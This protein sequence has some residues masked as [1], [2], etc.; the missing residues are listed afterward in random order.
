M[1]T[2]RDLYDIIKPHAPKC[3]FVELMEERKLNVQARLSTP[4]SLM[5]QA[6]KFIAD[7]TQSVEENVKIFTEK[8]F[9]TK[10]DQSIIFQ[11]TIGQSSVP[12]WTEQRKGRLT[13]SRFHQI[14]TRTKTLQETSSKDASCLL[15]SLLCY[16][17]MPD[18]ASIKHGCAMEPHAKAYYLP[19]TKKKHRKLTSSEAGLVVKEEKPYI[20][21]SSDLQIECICCGKGLVEVNCP[22]SIR[23]TVPSAENLKYLEMIGGKVVLKKNSN[24]YYQIQGQM[25]VTGRSYTDLVIFTS[26]KNII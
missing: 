5:V 24:Y 15:S 6:Q 21:V 13:A 3:C 1:K 4:P 2:R 11:N 10:E 18:T 22:Y 17:E 23:D 9:L 20:A 19:V 26:H 25:G 14:C 16:K 12:E 7:E 8:L